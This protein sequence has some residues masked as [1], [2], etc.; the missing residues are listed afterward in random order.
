MYLPGNQLAD[1]ITLGHLGVVPN[2]TI[3]LELHSIDPVNHPLKLVRPTLEYHMPDVI[4]VRINVGMLILL[5]ISFLC[6]LACLLTY[7]PSCL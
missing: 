3:Q 7:L 6:L 4:T 5:F 2:G 1:D